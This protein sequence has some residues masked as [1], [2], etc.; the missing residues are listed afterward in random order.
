MI[1]GTVVASLVD[2]VPSK[3]ALGDV[4]EVLAALVV[5]LDDASLN[6]EL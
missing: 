5:D 3:D 4:G 1:P 2:Q 6:E